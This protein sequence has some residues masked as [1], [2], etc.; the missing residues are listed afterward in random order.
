HLMLTV[1][2]MGLNESDEIFSITEREMEVYIWTA[3]GKT[4]NEIAVI[5]NISKRTVDFHI[6]NV[7]SKLG[8]RTKLQACIQLTK[9]GIL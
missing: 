1:L 2:F 7:I 3:I 9:M 5:L 6:S 4:C 8:V